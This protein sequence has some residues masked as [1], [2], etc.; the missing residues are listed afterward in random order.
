M[1]ITIDEPSRNGFD[2]NMALTPMNNDKKED[3][4]G[5]SHIAADDQANRRS[6]AW[7]IM[8]GDVIHNFVD[9]LSIGA[10][11]TEN[12]ALGISISLAVVCEEL[13]HELG[14]VSL[15]PLCCL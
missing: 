12:I 14:K 8:A 10:A 15:L 6:L 9:G 3:S 13:P 4:H 5:H 1:S 2:D 7:M 11:F